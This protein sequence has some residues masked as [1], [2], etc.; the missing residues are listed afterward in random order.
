MLAMPFFCCLIEGEEH[1]AFPTE[2]LQGVNGLLQNIE[3]CTLLQLSSDTCQDDT[4]PT[5]ELFIATA[6][7]TRIADRLTGPM[8]AHRCW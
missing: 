8:S 4:Q 5:R 1:L 7:T 6:T 3:P 2:G